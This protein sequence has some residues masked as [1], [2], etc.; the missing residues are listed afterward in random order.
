MDETL[1]PTVVHVCYTTLL[2]DDLYGLFVDCTI[3]VT[4]CTIGFY[5]FY[6][7]MRVV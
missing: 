4:G 7:P 5:N 2:Y 6:N 1:F 3:F